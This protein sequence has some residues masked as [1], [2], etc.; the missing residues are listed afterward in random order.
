M[1]IKLRTKRLQKFLNDQYEAGISEDGVYGKDTIGALEK[2]LDIESWAKPEFAIQQ[3]AYDARTEKNLATLDPAAAPTLRQLVSTAKK[4]GEA[5]AVNV[6]V[7]SGHRTW[8]EQ[9]RLFAQGRTAPGKIVTKARGGYSNHNFGIAIDFG[10]FKGSKYLDGGTASEK[11]LARK[12]HLQIAEAAKLD[13]LD[14]RWGG[15]WS[16]FKDLPH[17]EILIGMSLYEKRVSYLE[18]GS[19]MDLV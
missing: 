6:K 13:G 2:A 4:V 5:N 19:V 9:D 8:E 10:I 11:N 14:T 12:V 15:D 7:I 3:S 1:S 18:D 16:G 17:H